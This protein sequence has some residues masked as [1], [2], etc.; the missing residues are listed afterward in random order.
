MAKVIE[1]D[2]RFKD[3]TFFHKIVTLNDE[4][5]DVF[6][7]DQSGRNTRP[8]LAEIGAETK[9]ILGIGATLIAKRG[10]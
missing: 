6:L 3:G 10:G 4:K 9:P 1:I 2:I 7:Y 8:L 5:A